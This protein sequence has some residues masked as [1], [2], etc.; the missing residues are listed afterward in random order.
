M[1]K[2]TYICDRCGKKSS[3]LTGWYEVNQHV[4]RTLLMIYGKTHWHYCSKDCMVGGGCEHSDAMYVPLPLD[5]E[6]C[7]RCGH[8][9]VVR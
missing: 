7:L 9:R 6:E 2:V 5:V 4:D 1:K 8:I 3:S